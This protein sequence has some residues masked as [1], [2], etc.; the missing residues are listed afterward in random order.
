MRI[1]LL[2]TLA[3]FLTVNGGAGGLGAGLHSRKKK[4]AQNEKTIVVTIDSG[5]PQCKVDADGTAEGMT[6]SAGTLTLQ[7][8]QPGDHYLHVRCVGKPEVSRFMALRVGE[9]LE[10]D[11]KQ[12]LT[13]NSSAALS[14]LDAAASE[15]RLHRMVRQ[16]VQLRAS[17]DFQQTVMLLREATLLDPK[18]SDLHRELGITFLLAHDWERARVEM[19]EA[20][21]RDPGNAEAHS[22]LA[23]AYEKLGNLEEALKQ[24]RICTHLDPGDASYQRH[25]VEV[26][27]EIVEHQAQRKH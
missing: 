27:G 1:T 10:V 19:L 13:G 4:P 22:G 5:L 6:D 9:K 21:H 16:A 26:L 7:G 23:Y 12:A 15:A 24:Y 18:N 8:I 17:G 20:I 3:A 25:Y 2:L 14:P 11:I